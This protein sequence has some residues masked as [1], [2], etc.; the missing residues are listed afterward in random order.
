MAPP[1]SRPRST[2]Q[3][4]PQA[5]REETGRGGDRRAE[6]AHTASPDRREPGDRPALAP[7]A[8]RA[9]ISLPASEAPRLLREAPARSR[10][11]LRRGRA[12]AALLTT[13]GGVREA[14]PPLAQ[15]QRR[16]DLP[17]FHCFSQARAAAV[18][19]V[20]SAPVRRG[21]PQGGHL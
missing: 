17:G 16:T 21:P 12:A 5:G 14:P 13:P 15:T 18:S 11:P 1:P 2:G 3:G 6:A 8:S 7:T 10:E 19:A 20:S 9:S 4:R